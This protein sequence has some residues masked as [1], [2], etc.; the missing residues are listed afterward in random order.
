MSVVIMFGRRTN[1]DS[2][3]GIYDTPSR[4]NGALRE[5]MDD[6]MVTSSRAVLVWNLPAYTP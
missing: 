2:R 6:G 4:N 5:E 3:L 1:G